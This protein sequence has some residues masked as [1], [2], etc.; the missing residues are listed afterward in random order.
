M[1]MFEDAGKFGKEALDNSLKSFAAATKGFQAIAAEV[2]EF[3]KSNLEKGTAAFEQLTAARSLEKAVEVQTNYT[4]S[5]YEN[6][7]AQA[8]RMG[9]LYAN[10]AKD[11]YKPFETALAKA[12]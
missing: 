4:K 1:N 10:L 6:F 12:R 7:V 3:T 2:G 9:E 11:A 5:A 8:T